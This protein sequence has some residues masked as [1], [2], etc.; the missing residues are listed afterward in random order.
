[1]SPARLEIGFTAPQ[2]RQQVAELE[3]LGADSLWVGGHIAS[4]NPS[5]EALVWLARLIEQTERVTVGTATL[6][7]P[8]YPPG[9]LAK[10]VADLDRA[11]AGRLR[12]GIG[13]GGEYLSDFSASEVPIDE[14]GSRTDEAIGLLRQFWTAETIT[15]HGRHHTFEKVRIHPAP[16]QPSGPPIIVSGRK[17][18][19]MRRA[20]RV[21][22]G[23]MPYLYSP[24]RYAMSVTKIREEAARHGRDLTDFG[25][26]AYVF[27]SMD[28]DAT[29][30]ATA[31]RDFFGNT[32]RDDFEQ[33]LDRVACVGTPEQVTDRLRAFVQAGARHLILVP[34][35][36]QQET[37]LRILTEIRPLLDQ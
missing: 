34:C 2:D 10:Q 8:L 4:T 21:G 1:M 33:F 3:A 36:R 6:L 12:L 5:P 29:V 20:A 19:A 32:Y 22:D 23:W 31:A 11:A 7:L 26:Y 18:V 16:A 25:W 35:A 24:E 17:Q 27:V 28:D 30:A 15:H 14:R 37:Y 9:I 13:V